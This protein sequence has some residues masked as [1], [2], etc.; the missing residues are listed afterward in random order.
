MFPQGT[1][2]G[3]GLL[4]EVAGKRSFSRVRSNVNQEHGLSKKRLVADRAEMIAL[5]RGL[6]H[7]RSQVHAKIVQSQEGLSADFACVGSFLRRIAAPGVLGVSFQVV[8]PGE[9]C[10]AVHADKVQVLGHVFLE[11]FRINALH[12]AFAALKLLAAVVQVDGVLV[13][14]H[15]RVECLAAELA[16]DVAGLEGDLIN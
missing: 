1:V 8:S 3:K 16:L 14:T 6:P 12:F 15:V 5:S 9:L 13:A 4:A 7:V 10:P 11:D 2:R